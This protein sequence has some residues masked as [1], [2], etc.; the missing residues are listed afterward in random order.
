MKNTVA[1]CCLHGFKPLAFP[2]VRRFCG[3]GSQTSSDYTLS[4]FL[5]CSQ[6]RMVVAARTN[7]EERRV[8]W[9][10]VGVVGPVDAT[11]TTGL[12]AP[13]DI[14]LNGGSIDHSL[15]DTSLNL[16]PLWRWQ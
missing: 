1:E 7:I 8:A 6:R 2:R 15:V 13:V 11:T 10:H 14:N 4:V 16:I 3:T 12:V 9:S 5:R